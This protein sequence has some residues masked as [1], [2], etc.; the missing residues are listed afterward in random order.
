MTEHQTK[1]MNELRR[2]W[3]ALNARNA[4]FREP[5][6]NELQTMGRICWNDAFKAG[7]AE[8]KILED[9]LSFYAKFRQDD[10][11]PLC[12]EEVWMSIMSK[13]TGNKAL[14]ALKVF[15]EGQS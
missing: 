9:T 8:A 4:L 13:D 11:E 6:E 12:H 14:T 7:L 5:T 3:V 10:K 2:Q 15:R 1:K